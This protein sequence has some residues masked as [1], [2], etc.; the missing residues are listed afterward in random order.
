MNSHVYLCMCIFKIWEFFTLFI[1]IFLLFIAV[2]N[3]HYAV[4]VHME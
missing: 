3:G 1:I 2:D 4:W